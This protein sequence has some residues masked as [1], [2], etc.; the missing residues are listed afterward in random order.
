MKSIASYRSGNHRNRQPRM[1][2]REYRST[3]GNLTELGITRIFPRKAL[4]EAA[5]RSLSCPFVSK[6]VLFLS[7][8]DNCSVLDSAT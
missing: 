5:A 7:Q 2:S 1:E 6:K 8:R 3:T 4:A